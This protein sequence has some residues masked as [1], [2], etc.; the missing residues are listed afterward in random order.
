MSESITPE[1][2]N[3]LLK[4]CIS[5]V[6]GCLVTMLALVVSWQRNRSSEYLNIEQHRTLQTVAITGEAIEEYTKNNGT[7]PESLEDLPA[8]ELWFLLGMT[9]DTKYIRDGWGRPLEYAIIE[10]K[11]IATSYGRDGQPGGMGLDYDISTA[12][13]KPAAAYPTLGQYALG[14]DS[15]FMPH[16]SLIPSVIAGVVTAATCFDMLKRTAL[17]RTKA[18]GLA[19]KL[20]FVAGFAA[21]F[22]VVV[23]ALA[24]TPH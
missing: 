18:A 1:S 24:M 22:A 9:G 2:G 5:I 16:V 4:L 20:L 12:E 10:G 8:D 19:V 21:F 3:V 14:A 15:L 13:P 11:G 6:V 7:A 23:T 17:S